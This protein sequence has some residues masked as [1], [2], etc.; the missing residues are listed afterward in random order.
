M[1]ACL[2]LAVLS[3]SISPWIWTKA[4]LS[5]SSWEGTLCQVILI[6]ILGASSLLL[7][8][9]AFFFLPR[10]RIPR[11]C[12]L[13]HFKYIYFFHRCFLPF[14]QILIQRVLSNKCLVCKLHPSLFSRNWTGTDRISGEQFGLQQEL[15]TDVL[16]FPTLYF[17]SVSRHSRWFC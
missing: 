9:H 10:Q 7:Y 1:S 16:F 3:W 4:F 6:V 8:R 17:L 2:R 13:S 14:L 5:F 12:V 15:W 11:D